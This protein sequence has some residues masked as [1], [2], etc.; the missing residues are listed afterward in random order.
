MSAIRLLFPAAFLSFLQLFGQGTQSP[1]DGAPSGSGLTL[2]MVPKITVTGSPGSLASIEWSAEP[3]GPWTPWTNVVHG[4]Q[5]STLVDLSPGAV[6][7][8]YRVIYNLTPVAREGFIWV[9]PGTFAMGSPWSE[10]N[11]ELDE[12]QHTVTI[13]K[14]FWIS[15][16]EVTQ[17][18]FNK[19]MDGGWPFISFLGDSRPVEGVSWYDANIYCRRLTEKGR[20]IGI[21]TAQ[22]QYRL[23]TEAEW[24]YAARAGTTGA[25]YGEKGTVAWY[26]SNSGGKTHSV[27]TKAPNSWGAYDMLGN[28][29]EWC[30]DWYGE[31]IGDA[32]NPVGPGSGSVKVVRGG[33]WTENI[34]LADRGKMFPESRLSYIGFRVVLTSSQ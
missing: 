2:E 24:E 8:F 5:G 23:P 29:G 25:Q 10:L 28:V 17:S 27:K 6:R 7:R 32:T 26:G 33:S 1:S 13:T 9:N 21:I 15:D 18:E 3:T 22:Q 4:V 20:S 11:R 31:Y 19:L 14:G 34:R 16:H 12:V 30:S